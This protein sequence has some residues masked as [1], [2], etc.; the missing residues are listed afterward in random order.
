MGSF[1]KDFESLPGKEGRKRQGM[2]QIES[3]SH[4]PEEASP[5]P[6]PAPA[7][8]SRH[9]VEAG[10]CWLIWVP[11]SPP[12]PHSEEAEGGAHAHPPGRSQLSALPV[13]CI[14]HPA[15]ALSLL[16]SRLF[17]FLMLPFF[18]SHLLTCI[19]D[20][21]GCFTAS[22]AVGVTK[23]PP[24]VWQRG[25]CPPP[26][27]RIQASLPVR[28]FLGAEA[29]SSRVIYPFLVTALGFP[30]TIH[31]GPSSRSG[32]QRHSTCLWWNCVTWPGC[33]FQEWLEKNKTQ[34]LPGMPPRSSTHVRLWEPPWTKF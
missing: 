34:G 5:H 9:P 15:S 4:K 3:S 11:S 1:T 32:M 13:G 8:Q 31:L 17:L 10:A 6:R 12:R 27:L 28:G 26:P 14:P 2:C 20:L 33:S 29:H 19:S 24:H 22:L 30:S 16:Y 25:H 21:P 18:H 23:D 7:S